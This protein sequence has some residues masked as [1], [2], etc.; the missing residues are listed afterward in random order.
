MNKRLG[1]NIIAI[2]A[3]ILGL[4]EVFE[5]PA[6][7][8]RKIK[9]DP[10]GVPLSPPESA[11]DKAAY[12]YQKKAV[13]KLK[14]LLIK[15]KDTPQESK[16]LIRLALLQQQNADIAF[17]IAHADAFAMKKSIDLT[18]YKRLM[19]DSIKTLDRMVEKYPQDSDIAQAYLMRARANEEVGKRQFAIRDYRYL[20]DNFPRFNDRF[21]VFL[22][23]AEFAEETGDFDES[24]RYLKKLETLKTDSDY[25]P[26]ALYK[27]AWG[28]YNLKDPRR[29]MYYV[30]RYVAYQNGHILRGEK[31]NS[32]AR[33]AR[34][35]RDEM[36][37]DATTFYLKGVE[38]G[39]PQFRTQEA[40]AYFKS[41][42]RGP[43]STQVLSDMIIKFAKLLRA[44]GLEADLTSWKDQVVKSE[45]S[46]PESL[47][48]L[49]L[50]FEDQVNKIR[51]EKLV[52]TAKDLQRHYQTYK[53]S[54]PFKGAEDLLL[55]QANKIQDLIKKHGKKS[56]TSALSLMLAVV[57]KT[58]LS[59][60]SEDSDSRA[61]VAHYN[62]AEAYSGFNRDSQAL[63]HYVWILNQARYKKNRENAKQ[64][65]VKIDDAGLKA[66]SIRH[67]ELV[68][69][70][71]IPSDLK[72][73]S[74]EKVKIVELEPELTEWIEWIGRVQG[75]EEKSVD[76]EQIDFYHFEA[77][78]ALYAK[79]HVSDAVDRMMVFVERNPKSKYA[80]PAASLVLDTMIESQKWNKAHTLANQFMGVEA[81]KGSS[82]GK[83]LFKVAADS[84]YKLTEVAFN[85]GNF[86]EV[87]KRAEHFEKKYAGSD[88][89]GD[90]LNLVSRSALALHQ[91]DE[92]MGFLSQLITDS[93]NSRH[94]E[95]SLLLRANAF[96]KR[97]EFGSAAKDF[98]VYLKRVAS[99]PKPAL[100][101]N[102]MNALK[103]KIL[104]LTWLGNEPSQL[105][106]LTS[107]ALICGKSAV[108]CDQYQA[109]ALNDQF[110]HTGKV[111]R[112]LLQPNVVGTKSAKGNLA[113][114][115]L[116]ALRANASL[117]K[118]DR[119]KLMRWLSSGWEQLDPVL[120]FALMPH[121]VEI[122]PDTVGQIRKSFSK[123]YPVHADEGSIAT[124][125]KLIKEVERSA[126]D[127]L[128]LPW[129][130]LQG[131]VLNEVAGLY[132]DLARDIQMVPAPK[133]LAE[134]ER[135]AY[136]DTM[137]QVSLP[138][139]R[140][141]KE[142]REKAFKIAS[143]FAIEDEVF[144]SI[145]VPYFSENPEV[146][147]NLLPKIEFPTPNSIGVDLLEKLDRSGG[148]DNLSEGA[149]NPTGLFKAVW[150]SALQSKQWNRV[151][152]FLQQGK[153][154]T[155]L[156]PQVLNLMRAISFASAG[157][158][159]E[160]LVLLGDSLGNFDGKQK[161]YLVVTLVRQYFNTLSRDKIKGILGHF[162]RSDIDDLGSDREENTIVVAAAH[163]SG[164]TK[165]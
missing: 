36:L 146:A 89:K 28:Y 150:A 86:S 52:D 160:S 156:S 65:G 134:E 117:G 72:P 101:A 42:A 129:A 4:L 84:Y 50:T 147:E 75:L 47:E 18:F 158:R 93:S 51:Y 87:I 142:I 67:N 131:A 125:S 29:S 91:D 34:L 111:D 119:L 23:L 137:S 110:S 13:L 39:I 49:L 37:L 66:I 63:S 64:A 100:N 143:E 153:E 98:M 104:L 54:Y 22:A 120:K 88:R 126:Q 24:I 1:F 105:L 73:L 135:T 15:K 38:M 14:R 33:S 26:F 3:L 31:E 109:L 96:E 20:E 77:S 132:M 94:V 107:D 6:H 71:L 2:A 118:D 151:A 40:M 82:F 154:K 138:F 53:D 95:D 128:K 44:G 106:K 114:W 161:R 99:Q 102:E 149:R 141:G 163:W 68:Q 103:E 116:L 21:S 139:E 140:S 123:M 124:R 159:A 90:F 152:Y 164:V 136:R 46:R 76:Q 127:V 17:R 61:L 58:F 74:I 30:T 162:A 16:L 108:L 144:Q 62:L 32:E 59:L 56:D 85:D 133:G 43:G 55:G 70:G 10:A 157:A 81:W 19:L 80:I 11:V 48:V 155:V 113:T 112:N 12:S 122:I 78:R 60:I 148:W 130:R 8:A 69:K 57:Y 9:V 41:L 25:Y 27:L 115:S 79:G 83:K 5:A 121:L 97:Y 35:L 7:A 45:G 165:E 145:S 92:A